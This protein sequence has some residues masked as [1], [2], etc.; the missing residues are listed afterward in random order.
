MCQCSK[1]LLT[2]A[3]LYSPLLVLEV[4]WLKA[5][6]DFM[7]GLSQNQRAMDSILE[8]VVRFYKMAKF[9]P[10][11]KLWLPHGLLI[12]ILKRLCIYMVSD[13]PLL[14]SMTPSF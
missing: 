6:M 4:S 9:M 13:S 11:K 14:P 1:E 10:A 2:N 7:L 5:I 8:V 3:S 12:C